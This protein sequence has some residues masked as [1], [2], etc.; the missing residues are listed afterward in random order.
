M[1]IKKDILKMNLWIDRE[2]LEKVIL[3]N[4]D[5]IGSKISIESI[6]SIV[7]C[8]N[9]AFTSMTIM[10]RIAFAVLA[11]I[12]TMLLVKNIFLLIHKKSDYKVLIKEIEDLN[13]NRKRYTLVALEYDSKFLLYYDEGNKCY[14]FPNFKTRDKDNIKYVEQE[15]SSMLNL[16]CILKCEPIGTQFQ[17]LYSYEHNEY[18]SYEHQI[19]R[20]II[21]NKNSISFDKA[22]KWMSIPEMEADKTIMERNGSVV[23]LVKECLKGQA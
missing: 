12:S 6:I 23:E 18:R 22:Y 5:Y 7:S 13:L 20:T 8:I 17:E 15:L 2:Q 3:E 9:S 16:K 11:V 4:K 21:K 19:Y 14:F 1:I 10:I